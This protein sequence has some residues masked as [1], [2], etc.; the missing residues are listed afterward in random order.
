MVIA[1]GADHGGY[2]YKEYIKNQIKNVDFIDVG[3]NTYDEKDDYTDFSFAAAELVKNK[4]ADFAVIICRT[5]VGSVMAM[6]K[7][8]GV[9]A[10]LCETVEGCHIAR[11]KNNINAVSFGAD[12]IC[13]KRAVRIVNE[14]IST[15]FEG[16]RHKRRVDKIMEYERNSGK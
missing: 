15:E 13:K 5:G 6:N 16:G 4:K 11:Q 2:L 1:I 7:V 9:R 3:A 8:R 10:G 12:N 14:L